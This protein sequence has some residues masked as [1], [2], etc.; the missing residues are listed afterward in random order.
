MA[1][2]DRTHTD[3]GKAKESAATALL[4]KIME[5]LE[6]Y[7]TPSDVRDLAESYALVAG[8]YTGGTKVH[9]KS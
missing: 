6:D 7:D 5:Q 4:K 2:D 1:L 9:V 8:S 3:Y